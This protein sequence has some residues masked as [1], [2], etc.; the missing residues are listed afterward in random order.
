M[1]SPTIGNVDGRSIDTLR[2][3]TTGN[4]TL[5]GTRHN[6]GVGGAEGKL[7][8]CQGG[9]PEAVR[10]PG[11]TRSV[12]HEY[13]THGGWRV[14]ECAEDTPVL[15]PEPNVGKR[16]ALS[17]SMLARFALVPRHLMIGKRRR[18]L[19]LKKIVV[20]VEKI[21]RRTSTGSSSL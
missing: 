21:F 5:V 4:Q 7:E 14:R 19:T 16:I 13:Q 3:S 1:V 9:V 18:G 2:G 20:S 11:V 15:L 17:R 10:D 8:R 6:R 12:S